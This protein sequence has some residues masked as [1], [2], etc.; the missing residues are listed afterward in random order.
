MGLDSDLDFYE[1]ELSKVFENKMRGRLGESCTRTEI[2]ML[3]SVARVTADGLE[4]EAGPRH[5]EL[6]ASS[7]NMTTANC[8]NARRERSRSRLQHC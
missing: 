7:M 1:A 6:L 4:Y 5:V 2:K 8:Q 3:N